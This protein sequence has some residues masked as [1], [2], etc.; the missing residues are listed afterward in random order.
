MKEITQGVKAVCKNAT[1]VQTFAPKHQ[2]LYKNQSAI[3]FVETTAHV[4]L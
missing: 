4:K 3:C 2:T 1:S